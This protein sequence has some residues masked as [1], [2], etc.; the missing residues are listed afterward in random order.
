MRI[1][2]R[3][4]LALFL[5]AGLIAF[6]DSGAVPASPAAALRVPEDVRSISYFPARGGW[7]LMWTRFDADAIDRDLAR[8]ASL[9]ANTVRV[10]VPVRV[11]GYPEPEA[12]DDRAARDRHRSRRAQRPLRRAHALRLVARLRGRRRVAPV[13][14]GAAV[15]VLRGPADR[16]RGAEER[17]PAAGRGRRRVGSG[18]DP[19]RPRGRS[20]PGRRLRAR[21]RPGS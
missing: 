12:G 2:V 10:I 15:E 9:H 20:T 21:A 1:P 11:F 3:V 8:V 18:V 4:S 17:G 19:V 14:Y 13:G 6:L 16:I 5:A 7:T